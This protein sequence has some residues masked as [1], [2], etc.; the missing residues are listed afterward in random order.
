MSTDEQ[1]NEVDRLKE[2]VRQLVGWFEA[3]IHHDEKAGKECGLARA[4][5]DNALAALDDPSV[6]VDDMELSLTERA[7]DH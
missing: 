7:S 2:V 6:S 5:I 1:L 4:A 3:Y